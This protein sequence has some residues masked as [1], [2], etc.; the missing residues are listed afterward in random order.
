MVGSKQAWHYHAVFG[1]RGCDLACSACP[2]LWLGEAFLEVTRLRRNQHPAAAV[3]PFHRGPTVSKTLAEEGP[4][5]RMWI[6]LTGL[7]FEMLA[8]PLYFSPW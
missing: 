2:S 1:G 5:R 3:G 6:S 8:I 7:L 4:V